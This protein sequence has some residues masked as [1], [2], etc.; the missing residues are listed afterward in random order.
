MEQIQKQVLLHYHQG[1]A[2]AWECLLQVWPRLANYNPFELFVLLNLGILAAFII[3]NFVSKIS[4]VAVYKKLIRALFSMGPIK[5]KV[6]AQIEK[7]KKD[8]L[9]TYPES[10]LPKLEK[11]PEKV[12]QG[13]IGDLCEK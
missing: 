3:I 7:A 10:L 2:W 4:I 6:Q 9:A 8:I 12:P 1:G 13:N 5:G 11:I